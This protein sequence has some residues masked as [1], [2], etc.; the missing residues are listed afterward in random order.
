MTYGSA[1][2]AKRRGVETRSKRFRNAPYNPCRCLRSGAAA[3]KNR[4]LAG[5]SP[6]PYAHSKARTFTIRQ[7]FC[8]FIGLL[9]H[10]RACAVWSLHNRAKPLCKACRRCF[11]SLRG[12]KGG[13]PRE[14]RSN[15]STGSQ[16]SRCPPI[17]RIGQTNRRSAP[18][19]A[20]RMC[21]PRLSKGS[22]RMCSWSCSPEPSTIC[23]SSG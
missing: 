5:S 14:R 7:Y 15:R 8:G 9:V 1:S 19:P 18:T 17:L 10:E 16:R 12:V 2:P 22:R 3:W 11:S 23:R 13:A 6:R 20:A 4:E 21:R